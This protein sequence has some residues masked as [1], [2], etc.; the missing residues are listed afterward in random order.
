MACMSRMT[1]GTGVVVGIDHIPTLTSLAVANLESDTFRVS[2]E[3]SSK[4][5][6]TEAKK[7]E[8]EKD[9][10]DDGRVVV[11]LG[12][13]REGCAHLGPYDAIHVGAACSSTVPSALIRQLKRPGRLVVP[14]AHSR[15]TRAGPGSG[16]RTRA[17]DGDGHGD[18]TRD[19]DGGWD[20]GD[21][22]EGEQWL[23]SITKDRHGTVTKEKMFG[24]RYVPLC[25]AP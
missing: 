1:N 7:K 5:S 15:D 17:G 9:D 20:D 23:W 12:D 14:V 8:L 10:D 22:E 13:G 18:N 25:D 3:L 21:V 11:V 24:V 2:P 4:Q 16:T 19:D 6:E